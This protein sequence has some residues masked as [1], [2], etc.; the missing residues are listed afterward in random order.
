MREQVEDRPEVAAVAEPLL[1]AWRAMR[2]Q[3]AVLDRKLIEAAKGDAT[4]RLLMT[5]RGVSVVVAASFAAAVEAPE[6]FRHSRAVG[7]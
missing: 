4:C 1:T 6:H 2:D 7:A 3:I 5:C